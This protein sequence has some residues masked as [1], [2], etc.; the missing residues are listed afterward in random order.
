[1]HVCMLMEVCTCTDE[2]VEETG[3]VVW[4]GPISRS[5]PGTS[6]HARKYR[7]YTAAALSGD[8]AEEYETSSVHALAKL[9]SMTLMP[10]TSADADAC[11]SE[12]NPWLLEA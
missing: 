6:P 12:F 10:P 2:E 11:I 5:P 1:M 3:V 4:D 7:N 9:T 8:S